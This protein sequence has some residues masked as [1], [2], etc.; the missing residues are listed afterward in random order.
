MLNLALQGGGSH[1]AFTWGALDALLDQGLCDGRPAAGADQSAG[2]RGHP[3]HLGDGAMISR[4][5]DTGQAA[6]RE[7]LTR[8]HAAIGQ[9][10]TVDI[11]R[12]YLDDTRFELPLPMRPAPRSVG[13]G[14]RPWLARL[15]RASGA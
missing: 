14:F 10:A 3:P 8:H 4:L 7:W 1:G 12:D 2:A 15:L 6:A 13:R 5:F 9:H 11:R